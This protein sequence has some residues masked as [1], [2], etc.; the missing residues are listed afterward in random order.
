M[1]LWRILWTAA[2]FC[3][4]A[5]SRRLEFRLN[6]GHKSTRHGLIP[7]PRASSLRPLD[8]LNT[9]P[10]APGNPDRLYVDILHCPP[11]DRTAPLG[12]P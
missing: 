6:S 10:I 4:P 12:N 2:I 5:R 9:G 3:T 1:S 8:R 7:I 11:L